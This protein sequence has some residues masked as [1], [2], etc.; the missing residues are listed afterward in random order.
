MR[1][2]HPAAWAGLL[3]NALV[4]F[5]AYASLDS[6]SP[7]E[8][9]GLDPQYFEAMQLALQVARPV[10]L[11]LLLIQ[12]LALGLIASRFT[13][14]LVLAVFGSFFIMPVG[15]VYLIGCIYS[16][17]RWKFADFAVS[18]GYGGAMSVFRSSSAATMPYLA[19]GG[20]ALAVL[21]FA[22]RLVNPGG[23]FL[24]LGAVGL[25]F[26]SR[27]K[28]LYP[29][30]IHQDYFTLMPG[31]FIGPLVIPYSSV[32]SATL[33]DDESIR[34]EVETNGGTAMLSWSLLRVEVR[35]RR[36][37]LEGLGTALAE[38]HVPLY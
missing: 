15:L 6:L 34:F 31:L 16:H 26:T 27:A 1:Y 10:L 8:V 24:G 3:L 25:H 19:V 38:H 5:G 4:I 18:T 17:Y 12:A 21:C 35:Q 28:K 32:R 2:I 36:A 29:L 13:A 33:Y 30:S 37:A 7:S 20:L 22:F 11:L 9:P 14:G 23:M